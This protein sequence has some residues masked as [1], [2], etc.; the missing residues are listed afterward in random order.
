MG[1]DTTLEDPR[2]TPGD[3]KQSA[4]TMLSRAR[5]THIVYGTASAAECWNAIVEAAPVFADAV[6]VSRTI[7][8]FANHRHI[9]WVALEGPHGSAVAIFVRE[10]TEA[11]A[12]DP[13]FVHRE[14]SERLA[15]LSAPWSCSATALLAD[16]VTVPSRF[17]RIFA[18]A[19]VLDL[20]PLSAPTTPTLE[21]RFDHQTSPAPRT[22]RW[23][24]AAL[25]AVAVAAAMAVIVAVAM[26]TGG[27]ETTG[28]A[29]EYLSEDTTYEVPADTTEYQTP[30][31]QL[32]NGARLCNIFPGETFP[33]VAVNETT[34]CP[35]AENVRIEVIN[36]DTF[37]LTLDAYSPQLARHI[38]MGCAWETD[39]VVLCRGGVNAWVALY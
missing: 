24:G 9:V 23:N 32:P 4:Y 36:A 38:T 14:I 10:H 31:Y 13:D 33:H 35:F 7:G 2:R 12:V 1:Y 27:S 21:R 34:T 19:E 15:A 28:D 37:A 16:T 39:A 11:D 22:P 17:A 18:S 5:R 20:A 8:T 3:P 25:A 26:A 29:A 30:E 6:A